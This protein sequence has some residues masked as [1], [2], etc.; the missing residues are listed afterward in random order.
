M[1][2]FFSLR[3]IYTDFCRRT[4]ASGQCHKPATKMEINGMVNK[5]PL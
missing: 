2:D 1:F 4:D 3:N 5:T